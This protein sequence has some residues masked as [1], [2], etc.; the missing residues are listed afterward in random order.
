MDALVQFFATFATALVATALGHF[1]GALER[2]DFRTS[3]CCDKR[4]IQ[5]SHT[6]DHSQSAHVSA[7]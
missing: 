2:F 1:G 6:P 5:R 4:V 3:E 7:N